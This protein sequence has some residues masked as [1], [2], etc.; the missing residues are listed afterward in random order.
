MFI[1]AKTISAG[2]LMSLLG[3]TKYLVYAGT[4]SMVVICFKL[5]AKFPMFFCSKSQ[6]CY[7]FELDTD[8]VIFKHNHA[9]TSNQEVSGKGQ[10]GCLG[11]IEANMHPRRIR[12][13]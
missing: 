12:N 4:F 13:E 2:E 6:D 9:T 8:Y 1:S 10:N 7:K 5:V 11:N 3:L